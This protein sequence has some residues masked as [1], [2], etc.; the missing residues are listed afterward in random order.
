MTKKEQFSGESAR[1]W[2]FS[3]EFLEELDELGKNLKE[4]QNYMN[5]YIELIHEIH[6]VLKSK[7]V[8]DKGAYQMLSLADV[9]IGVFMTYHIY[10]FPEESNFGIRNT[11]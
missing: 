2:I 11:Q 8:G 7:R 4:N 5:E 3:K 1:S 10:D 9:L 6:S